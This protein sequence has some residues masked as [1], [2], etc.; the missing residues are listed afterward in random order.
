MGVKF[1]EWREGVLQ[2]AIAAGQ[3]NPVPDAAA[4]AQEFSPASD[5]D[6]DPLWNNTPTH[7]EDVYGFTTDRD[8]AE[9]LAR[10]AQGL[11]L[12]N[13]PGL[14]LDDDSDDAGSDAEGWSEAEWEGW[15]YDLDRPKAVVEE[16]A[17][18]MEG[19]EERRRRGAVTPR[20]SP[21][22]VPVE[23]QTGLV[24]DADAEV[25]VHAER[26]PLP[27]PTLVLQPRMRSHSVALDSPSG[28]M[29]PAS[30]SSHSGSGSAVTPTQAGPMPN[31]RMR[32]STISAQPQ[33]PSQSQLQQYSHS[34]SRATATASASASTSA[35][36]SAT[37]TLNSRHLPPTPSATTSSLRA[38]RPEDQNTGGG[39]VRSLM[40]G[41][42]MRAGKESF[43]R[44]LENALDF[45]EGK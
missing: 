35:S 34:H 31:G 14:G 25:D 43:M 29:S 17:V 30:V 16:G 15:A 28:S 7:V 26:A 23:V 9:Y 27:T 41:L 37:S 4:A 10:E 2:R 6:V 36:A 11:G 3:G 39:G 1:P 22:A 45:V 40:R 42:S 19:M 20:G 24:I 21:V 13:G 38:L 44:G 8:Y 32:A 5:A 33:S 18:V 12:G